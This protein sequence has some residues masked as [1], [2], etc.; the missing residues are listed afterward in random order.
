MAYSLPLPVALSKAR[1]KV[2]I[3]DKEIREPPHVTVLRGTGAWRID[4]RNG[5]FMDKVP[6]PKS[7]PSE[8]IDL[9]RA[10]ATWRLLCDE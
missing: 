5:E 6:D 7:V 10:E 1:W 8:L 4:L 3:R 2:K 9:I